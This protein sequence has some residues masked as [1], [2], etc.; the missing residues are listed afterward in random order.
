MLFAARN[1]HVI[2]LQDRVS[3]VILRSEI[4]L[5]LSEFPDRKQTLFWVKNYSPSLEYPVPLYGGT[6]GMIGLR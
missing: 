1:A 5:F 6:A 4:I 2:K 3:F